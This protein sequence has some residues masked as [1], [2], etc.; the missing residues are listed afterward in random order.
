MKGGGDGRGNGGRATY[1]V[2]RR[3]ALDAGR[4]GPVDD[5]AC[6][7]VALEVLDN[8]PHDRVTLVHENT[9][10]GSRRRWWRRGETRWRRRGYSRDDAGMIT[11]WTG[12]SN[13]RSRCGIRSS[14][15]LSKPS[16]T[17]TKVFFIRFHTQGD[18]GSLDPRRAR[19]ERAFRAHRCPGAARDA[20]R[21][22]AATQAHRRGFRFASERSCVWC[23]LASVF[24]VFFAFS[25]FDFLH[26]AFVWFFLVG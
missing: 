1:S 5:D 24:L 3:D 18:G 9:Q 25:S 7:V 14:L 11:R 13:A 19:L 8:L 15:A 10:M 22:T 20:A 4:W 2:E 17:T 21:E 12:S 16:A 23:V 26:L 6:F